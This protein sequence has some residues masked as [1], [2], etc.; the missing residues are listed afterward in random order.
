[1]LSADE[2]HRCFARDRAP[3]AAQPHLAQSG[4]SAVCILV[5]GCL[6]QWHERDFRLGIGGLRAVGGLL[7]LC[8]VLCLGFGRSAI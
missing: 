5:R 4:A 7:D 1:M 2:A 6:R 3:G 8:P